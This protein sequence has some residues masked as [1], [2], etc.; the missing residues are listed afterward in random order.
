LEVNCLIW[1]S[2][3]LEVNC[4][5]WNSPRLEL[6]SSGTAAEP[7]Y[8]TSALTAQKT[9]LYCWLALTAQK[10]SHVVLIVACQL[11]A[12][13]MFTSALR[14]NGRGADLIENSPSLE[15]CLPTRYGLVFVGRLL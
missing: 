8:I 10:T 1:N 15:V 13:D 5:I 2:P 4:L 7:R 11:T 3:R 14:S 9:Q 6:N 12:A